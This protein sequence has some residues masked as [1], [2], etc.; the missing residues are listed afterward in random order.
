MR[1]VFIG[2][3]DFAA[4]SLKKLLSKGM[5]VVAVITAA[6]KKKGRG[7]TIQFSAVKNAA[8]ENGL[9]VLQPTS[10]KDS[11]FLEELSALEPDLTVV[12]A[13]RMLPQSVW[14]MPR[15]GTIN[16][17]ASLLP[18]Y[19]GAAPINWA[20]INGETSTGLT[21][22][23]LKHEIDTGDIILQKKIPIGLKMNAG[24]LHDIMK[25]KGADLLIE[26]IEQIEKGVVKSIPQSK[27]QTQHSELKTAP[28]IFREHCRI[29]WLKNA[30]EV[31]NLIRGLSPYPGAFGTFSRNGK[32]I[33]FKVYKASITDRTVDRNSPG[34]I[35]ENNRFY[36]ACRDYYLC[37][38]S[39]QLE[40]KKR[41]DGN[42]FLRGFDSTGITL[43]TD[44]H[45][46]DHSHSS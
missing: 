45:V 34:Y 3:P 35:I 9:P 22:F 42:D 18:D 1:I 2:T 33:K 27:I 12:V 23:R 31:Y 19:R 46:Q 21:T 38:E 15:L 4:T 41:M 10:M 14:S 26:T 30:M 25:E 8:I 29:N 24:E 11:V 28:K 32:E 40:G 36:V 44:H 5:D 43:K 7:Q 39:L 6:D 20:L 37:L 13:F 17:H 16:L